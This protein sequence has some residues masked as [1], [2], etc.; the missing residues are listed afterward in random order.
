MAYDG[1]ERRIHKVFITRNSEYHVKDQLCVGVRDRETGEWLRTHFALERPVIG[2][3][4]FF[5]SGAMSAAPGLPSIG[6]S[7]YFEDLGRDLVTS[8]VVSVERPSP[9]IVA[10]YSAE[11]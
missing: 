4:K 9:D 11:S 1:P 8:S 2:A 5:E 6:E 3:V 10:T 7:M